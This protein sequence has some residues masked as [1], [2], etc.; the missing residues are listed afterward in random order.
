M[1]KNAYLLCSIVINVPH[2][3]RI[4]K[5]EGRFLSCNTSP[6]PAIEFYDAVIIESTPSTATQPTERTVF[7]KIRPQQ[8]AVNCLLLWGH[9]MH[10]LCNER[11]GALFCLAAANAVQF[12]CKMSLL[13][14]IIKTS[15]PYYRL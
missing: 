2:S 9:S 11:M 1:C 15:I 7:A 5:N 6:S 10:T 3:A 14:T 12:W 4:G 13:F 8:L